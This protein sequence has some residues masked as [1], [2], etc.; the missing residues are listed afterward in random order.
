MMIWGSY[1]F[2]HY[3]TDANHNT[4]PKYQ[5]IGQITII[6]NYITVPVFCAER[7]IFKL[8]HCKPD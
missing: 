4:I 5:T 6:S 1:L 3:N 7:I 8:Q 2:M